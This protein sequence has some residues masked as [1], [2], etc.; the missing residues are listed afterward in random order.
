M[1]WTVRATLDLVH[2]LTTTAEALSKWW[3]AAQTKEPGRVVSVEDGMVVI[4]CLDPDTK[5]GSQLR[6]GGE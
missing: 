5:L 6:F 1:R 2:V 3:D 4:S